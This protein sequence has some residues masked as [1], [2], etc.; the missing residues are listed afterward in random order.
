MLYCICEKIRKFLLLGYNYHEEEDLIHCN[1]EEKTQKFALP[2]E[3]YVKSTSALTKLWFDEI[4]L[5]RN[6]R[7]LAQK[8]Y[9]VKST[10]YLVL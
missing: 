5:F 3:N 2:P 10:V 4:F 7:I 1:C 6:L 8:K 9:F